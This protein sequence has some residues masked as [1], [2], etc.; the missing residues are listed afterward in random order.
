MTVAISEKAQV[1]K[2]IALPDRLPS[3]H[4]LGRLDRCDIDGV[5]AV[6]PQLPSWPSEGHKRNRWQRGARQ[7]LEW[8]LTYPGEG[9]HD[10]WLAADIHD[11]SWIEKVDAATAP[12]PL[13]HRLDGMRALLLLRVV[14]PSYQFLHNYKG[15]VLYDNVRVTISP[16]LFTKASEE[17]TRLGMTGAQLHRPLITLAKLAL[18]TG[19]GLSELQPEDFFQVAAECRA[20]GLRAPGL[21][22]AW[23]LLRGIGVLP[24]EQSYRAAI[25]A[26]QRTTADLVDAQGLCCAEIRDVLV[27]YCEERR[28]AMD[29]GSFRGLVR[30]LA[31]TFWADLEKHHPGIDSLR[32]PSDVALAWKERA[33]TIADPRLPARPRRDYAHLL[34]RVRAFYL[35]VQEWAHEDP[36]WAPYAAPSPVRKNDTDGYHKVR[37]QTTA[38]MHQ[39]VRERLPQL[40]VLVRAAERNR[41]RH[42]TL[43]TRATA[44]SL[45]ETFDHDGTTFLRTAPKRTLHRNERQRGPDNVW[46]IDL[47]S[48]TAINVTNT[49]NAAFWGWA[50][51]ETLRHTGVRV[52]ELLEITQLALTSY[53]LRDT[54]EVVPLLQI[55]PSKSNSERLLL[56]SPE[57]ASVLATI[58]K[59]VRD[60][61]TG[62]IPLTTRYDEHECVTGPPLPHIFKHTI[63]WRHEVISPAQVQRLLND[64]PKLAGLT[65]ATG[66]PLRYTPHDFR[67]IF[68]TDAVA[69][70]L[71]VHIAAR[72]L[73]H[74]NL[75]TTQAYLAV[76]QED[77]VRS[78]RAFLAG[79]RALRPTAEYREPTAAEWQDFNDH[80]KLRKLGLGTCGRPYDTPCN[81]EHACVRCP[82]LQVDPDQRPR[83]EEIVTNLEER[84]AEA[85]ENGW[86]GEVQGLQ[87]SLDAARVK[88]AGLDRQGPSAPVSL[89]LP[90]IR[91][92]SV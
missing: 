58:I 13:N 49:E 31:G 55:V 44:T 40:P 23:D 36:S 45:G 80:F 22:A 28:P 32:L 7:V 42:Q 50:I 33:K 15:F 81:H 1:K 37:K 11:R 14:R 59:R 84:I 76:F 54:G 71:P 78:Y 4:P 26:G 18:R 90:V 12:A 48:N 38:A 74:E 39:R 91:D 35:D 57:L 29:Y 53:K 16:D 85:E 20:C 9:W 82:M 83:L 47:S 75:N 5:L 6:L 2:P 88:L 3:H 72:L 92:N 19:K 34:M 68:V 65:D 73:G 69:G 64:I 25:K 56:V 51:V 62:R 21:N 61:E 67:R 27:R 30:D 8:L 86:L 77:L 24:G 43:L 79:R 52:E 87:V 10:R 63:G 66:K 89:G 70:G 46:V 60:P 41:E 17:A